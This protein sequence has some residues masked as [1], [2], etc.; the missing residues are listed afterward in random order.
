MK[1]HEDTQY[2]TIESD[3][4]EVKLV[5][6]IYGK[7]YDMGHMRIIGETTVKSIQEVISYIHSMYPV[8]SLDLIDECVKGGIHVS[9]LRYL[10]TENSW[11]EDNF[12]KTTEYMCNAFYE[13]QKTILNNKK[14]KAL[15]EDFMNI[16]WVQIISIPLDETNELFMNATTWQEFFVPLIERVEFNE[17]FSDFFNRFTRF[18]VGLSHLAFKYCIPVRCYP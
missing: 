10:T 9:L 11:Y 13:N 4:I 14:V 17:D 3:G 16:T 8:T 6:T 7:L 15:W 2:I 5:K 12:G 1:I 18:Y